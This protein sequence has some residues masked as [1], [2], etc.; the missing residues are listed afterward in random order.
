MLRYSSITKKVVMALAGLFLV[1]FLIVHL[2]INLL[3]LAGDGGEKFGIAVTFM[4]TNPVI[5]VFEFVLFGGFILHIIVGVILTIKNWMSR[6][7]GY[8][9]SNQSATSFFSKYMFHTGV[10]VFVFLVIHLM[11]F[12]FVK[13]G[14]TAAPEGAQ[15]VHGSHDFYHMAI[16]LFSNPVYAVLYLV[17]LAV[18]GLHLNHAFS[19]A[20]QTLGLTHGKY[21]PV[22][23]AIATIFSVGVSLGFMLIPLYF[24][25]VV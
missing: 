20:F 23:Q 1:S 19:S 18:L 5:K 13:L 11:N 9:K 16:N 4:T 6:P 7:V 10:I 14:I 17:L 24:L 15:T 3:L 21:T 8:Y 25:F 12:Y 2:S 22:I